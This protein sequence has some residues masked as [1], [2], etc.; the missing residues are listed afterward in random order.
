MNK[1]VSGLNP[2]KLEKQH[3]TGNQFQVVISTAKKN[4]AVLG[5]LGWLT[6]RDSFI[7]VILSLAEVQGLPAAEKRGIDRECENKREGRETM[8]HA[9]VS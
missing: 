1:P 9:L 4:K 7:H 3:K 8:I 6:E 5:L 2:F